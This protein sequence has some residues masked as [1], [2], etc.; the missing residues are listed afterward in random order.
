MEMFLSGLKV[1]MDL[2][3]PMV[4]MEIRSST[5]REK[6]IIK[7][8]FGLGTKDGQEMTQKEVASLLGIP[9]IPYS[10]GA[11]PPPRR[12]RPPDGSACPGGSP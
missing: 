2:I 12:P 11:F 4:P 1:L 8:R 10:A 9:A 5:Q 3:R 7:L 6:R